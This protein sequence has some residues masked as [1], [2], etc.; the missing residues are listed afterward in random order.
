MGRPRLTEQRQAEIL[1]ALERCLLRDGLANTTVA[2]VAAE[3]GFHRTLINHYFGDMES[4]VGALL[5]ALA[6]ELTQSFRAATAQSPRL[7][8]VLDYLFR[9]TPSRARRLIGALRAADSESAKGP[10]AQMYEA[11]T[12]G[13]DACLRAEIPAA[14]AEQ[15][16]ATAFA[17]VCLAMSQSQLARLGV[18][19]SH[20]QGLRASAEVLIEALRWR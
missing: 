14:P 4:L 16:R 10:L 5:V 20:T 13:L 18:S 15:R 3:A 2:A 6:D 7:P 17:I 1:A 8:A 19:K 9:R 11:F 12:A